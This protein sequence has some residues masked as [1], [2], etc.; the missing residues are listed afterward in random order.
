M[1]SV[2]ARVSYKEYHPKSVPAPLCEALPLDLEVPVIAATQSESVSEGRR[3]QRSNFRSHTNELSGKRSST[4]SIFGGT[5][6]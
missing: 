5:E 2:N 3:E 1:S 6:I 4:A